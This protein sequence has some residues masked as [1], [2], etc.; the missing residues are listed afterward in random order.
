M[1]FFSVHALGKYLQRAENK[2]RTKSFWGSKK[3][4]LFVKNARG[5]RGIFHAAFFLLRSVFESLL[6]CQV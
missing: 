6:F 4:L 2:C 1:D 3:I 5:S